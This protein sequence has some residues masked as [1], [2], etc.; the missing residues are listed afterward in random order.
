MNIRYRVRA[1]AGTSSDSV[2]RASLF[3]VITFTHREGSLRCYTNTSEAGDKVAH[4][5]L[6]EED[7]WLSQVVL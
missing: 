3:L 2:T 6:L 7:L 4:V 1:M 5:L